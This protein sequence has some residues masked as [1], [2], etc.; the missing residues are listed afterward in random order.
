MY[1]KRKEHN[2]AEEISEKRHLKRMLPVAHVSNECVH[3]REKDS[4]AEDEK[5]TAHLTGQIEIN[6]E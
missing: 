4:S 5:D 6:S 2:E 3:D 1:K